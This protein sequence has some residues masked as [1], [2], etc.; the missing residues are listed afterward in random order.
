MLPFLC[1]TRSFL[2]LYWIVAFS[3]LIVFWSLKN[4][5]HFK[6]EPLDPMSNKGFKLQLDS[7]FLSYYTKSQPLWKCFWLGPCPIVFLDFEW[8]Q[9]VFET[10][11]KQHCTSFLIAFCIKKKCCHFSIHVSWIVWTNMLHWR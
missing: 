9:D 7:Y 8:L 10:P 11:P 3:N 5:P 4:N 1:S 6:C 2:K